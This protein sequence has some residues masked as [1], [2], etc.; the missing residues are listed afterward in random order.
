MQDS[1]RQDEPPLL[2]WNLTR[3]KD[4]WSGAMPSAALTRLQRD[5]PGRDL[6][7][8]AANFARD[9]F[10]HVPG[11]LNDAEV[12]RYVAAV[13]EAVATRKA[14]DRRTLDEKTPYE[15]SF[16]QC[17]YLWED[18]PSVAALTFHPK[19]AG[20]A[21]AFLGAERVRIWHDQA[22]YKEPGGRETDAHQDHAYW[23]IAETDAITAW[24][25]LVDV[26]ET[27]GCMGYVPGSQTGGLEFID[28][29]SKPGS[30][31]ALEAKH[32]AP[33]FVPAKAGDVLF[34]A[35]RTVHLAKANRSGQMRRVHTAIYF[36]DGCTRSARGDHPSLAR[37]GIA[38]GARIGGAATPVAWPLEGGVLPK[39]APWPDL[40]ERYRRAA[41]AGVLPKLPG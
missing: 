32:A 14:N 15:Q 3:S 21:A 8:L 16:I 1:P 5:L 31:K 35:A 34:H 11:V 30:G 20:L 17:E 28:I 26:D 41:E 25:P 6:A 23:P 38:P 24:M 9:G 7:A 19:V 29:F 12:A 39:P 36:A 18:F 22:L 33:I 40:G 13:D 10:V 37:D 27:I 2:V 4:T